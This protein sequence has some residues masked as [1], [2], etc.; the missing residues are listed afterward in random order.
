MINAIAKGFRVLAPLKHRSAVVR[1]LQ[2]TMTFYPSSDMARSFATRSRSRGRG[3]GGRGSRNSRPA[4]PF[5]KLSFERT[6]KIDPEQTTAVKDMNLSSITTEVLLKKGFTEM[7][8]VQSQSF[9]DVFEGKDVVARSRTGTGKTFAFGLPLIEKLVSNGSNNA[10]NN[11]GKVLPAILIL[12][13][14]RELAMQVAQELGSVLRPHR[15]KIAAVY[16]GVSFSQQQYSIEDGVN[17]IVGTPG[18]ILDHISRGTVDFSSVKHVVLDEG[19]TMLEMGFQQAVETILMSVKSPGDRARELA[20]KSLSSFSLEEEEDFEEQEEDF[21]NELQQK[22]NMNGDSRAS[23]VQMLLFSATMPPWICKLTDKLMRKPVFLDAVQEG[24]TRLADTITHYAIPLPITAQSGGPEARVNAVAGVLEDIIMSKGK[25]G[26]CIV[27]ANFKDDCN[28]LVSSKAFSRLRATSLHG[29]ISQQQRSETL[30]AFK[31]K[32]IDVLVATDV[33]A[34]GLDIAGVDL[35]VH[36]AL[37]NDADSYVHRSGRTGRAGRAGAAVALY[38]PNEIGRMDEYQRSLMFKFQHTGLPNIGD[39]VKAYADIAEDRV[40]RVSSELAGHFL[41]FAREMMVKGQAGELAISD[42]E[43]DVVDND[44]LAEK[45]AP[46]IPLQTEDIIARLL[47]VMSN[48]KSFASR[49]MLTGEEDK[50]TLRIQIAPKNSPPPSNIGDFQTVLSNFLNKKL[51]I[52]NFRFRKTM[53]GQLDRSETRGD[54]DRTVFLQDFDSDVAE[55]I[56]AKMENITVLGLS[57]DRCQKLPRILQSDRD[58]GRNGGRG[59]GRHGGRDREFSRSSS[60]Y[61]RN[62]G[63]G[64]GDRNNRDRFSSYDRDFDR[65]NNDRD[66][67]PKRRSWQ[68][69][70]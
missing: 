42:E 61:D 51:N 16:G 48:R 63:R 18:R 22:N 9:K 50:T 15:L 28:I 11:R 40:R 27:F 3:G 30:R 12:E 7:T 6:I 56:L 21:L 57:I 68:S 59:D 4:D 67:S 44:D 62:G 23:D 14:T 58:F 26:Q 66:H 38:T 10:R 35:V 69:G 39:V 32:R 24:E 20:T 5:E 64:N 43:V 37:P 33:A 31:E 36:T 2:P 49:S 13:P 52:T 17:I 53:I 19:D 60:P 47:A 29:D 25:G 41:P 65:R 54:S 34:R 70:R 45:K 8:P 55:D 46:G 1:S